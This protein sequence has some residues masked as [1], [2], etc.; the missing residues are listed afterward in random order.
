MWVYISL[1]KVFIYNLVISIFQ[2]NPGAVIILKDEESEHLF[3][4]SGQYDRLIPISRTFV[5]KF[6]VNPK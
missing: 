2:Q 4:A 1:G 6:M 3:T 5:E